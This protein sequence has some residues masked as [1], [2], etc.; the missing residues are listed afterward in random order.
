[1]KKNLTE[2]AMG[3]NYLSGIKDLS[4]MK[5]DLN[6]EINLTPEQDKEL[7]DIILKYVKDS[8]D[9]EAIIQ[10]YIDGET[11][12]PDIQDGDF[13][14][15]FEAWKKKHNIKEG[16]C[17]YS[18]DG[19]PADTPAGP[20]LIK[21][22]DLNESVRKVVRKVLKQV[23][24]EGN[25]FNSLEEEVN[26][27]IQKAVQEFRENQNRFSLKDIAEK[28]NLNEIE[29]ENALAE[30]PNEGNAF[31]VARLKAIKAGE[32]EFEVGGK[33]HKVT[34]VSDDDKEAAEKL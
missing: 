16:T 22:S 1:M 14:N 30:E 32:D 5:E 31:A 27:D 25:Y 26:E 18:V 19:K 12:R 7:L 21:K 10:D 11:N 6:E 13:A 17:G 29:L 20:N 33:K 34:D 2:A 9:A 24:K 3:F 28:Y 8:D 23:V 15:E 4:I